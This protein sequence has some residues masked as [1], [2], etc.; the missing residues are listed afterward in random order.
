VR[1][2]VNRVIKPLA[3]WIARKSS[4]ADTVLKAIVRLL[5]S[6]SFA[7][8]RLR[9]RE[10]SKTVLFFSF[11]GKKFAD[12]PRAI[13]EAMIADP[14]F[15]DW[16]FVWAFRGYDGIEFAA[17]FATH[18][19]VSVVTY[20]SR[21]FF[22]AL[23][24]AKYWVSNSH[25]TDGVM[26]PPSKVYLQTW[27]GTP[28]KRMGADIPTEGSKMPKKTRNYGSWYQLQA[29]K[30]TYL[31]SQS[32]Y[33][34]EKISAAFRI[35]ALRNPPTILDSGL[36]R[37]SKL[38]SSAPELTM[39]AEEIRS[40]LGISDGKKIALYAPTFRDNQHSSAIGYTY[41]LGVDFHKLRGQL[42]GD[43]VVLFRAHYFVANS[44]NFDDFDGFVYDVSAF[45][46]INDLFVVADVLVTDYSSSM[47]D[48]VNT[49]KPV[50][51]YAYDLN[52]YGNELRGFYIPVTEF[53]GPVFT[54]QAELA[55]SLNS[56]DRI[57]SEW[58]DRREVFRK[59]YTPWD[60]A[61]STQR[62]IDTVFRG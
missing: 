40:R 51:L 23:A 21:G 2:L 55:E 24:E 52:E 18:D 46:D 27:H 31:T 4:V 25:V 43:W 60:S 36:P 35:E 59:K 38:F 1:T 6:A 19:R 32:P 62:V 54:T 49:G 20:N 44:L 50:L 45:D 10:D 48:F 53:P 29:S 57:G 28:L 47:V 8:A 26:P 14:Q 33:F 13:F 3:I 5:Q 16:N 39:R 30:W 56:L 17:S 34:T 22:D 15:S 41:N 12:S 11:M 42:G 37:N 7:V 61:E 9:R 58:A